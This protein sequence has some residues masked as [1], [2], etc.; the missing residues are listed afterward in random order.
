MDELKSFLKQFLKFNDNLINKIVDSCK[1]LGD[2]YNQKSNL[3]TLYGLDLKQTKKCEQLLNLYNNYMKFCQIFNKQE[4]LNDFYIFFLKLTFN[5]QEEMIVLFAF[6]AKKN[7][8]EYGDILFLRKDDLNNQRLLIYIGNWNVACIYEFKK[9]FDENMFLTV[10]KKENFDAS[11]II[12][13]NNSK[14]K[15]IKCNA[16]LLRILIQNKID[17]KE[18]KEIFEHN[19]KCIDSLENGDV[20]RLEGY[21][22]FNLY[23]TYYH[24]LLITSIIKHI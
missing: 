1:S 14:M 21:K 16:N 15:W 9:Y 10:L 7:N 19:V 18:F 5:Y 22:L 4:N 2:L 23:V 12:S 20:L 17:F 6:Y 13:M 8:F 3:V 24:T 11:K